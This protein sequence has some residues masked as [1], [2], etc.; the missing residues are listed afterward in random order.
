MRM[1]VTAKIKLDIS[2]ESD[3]LLS[4]TAKAYRDACNFVSEIVSCA[5]FF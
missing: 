5:G 3:M 2:D 4:A 1:T